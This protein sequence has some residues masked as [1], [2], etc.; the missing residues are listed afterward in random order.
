MAAVAPK[1]TADDRKRQSKP[2]YEPAH[3]DDELEG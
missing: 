1:L 2:I 3:S